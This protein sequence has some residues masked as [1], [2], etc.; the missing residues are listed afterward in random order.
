M[1]QPT[2][3]LIIWAEDN[4][5]LPVSGQPNKIIPQESLRKTGWDEGQ[6][7]SCE[8]FNYILN[9]LA[10]YIN[11]YGTEKTQEFLTKAANLSD[12]AD[13]VAARNNLSVYSQAQV[14]AK[15]INTGAGLTGGG[16]LSTNRTISMAT[17]STVGAGSTN[18]A[19]NG[20]NPTH[21]HTLDVTGNVSV[22]TG[23]V[24]N[25]GTIPLPSGY[26]ES[27]CKWTVSVNF[28][29]AGPGP[30]EIDVLTCSLN[31]RVVTITASSPDGTFGG[32][33]N[34]LIIGVK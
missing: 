19:T 1:A 31:G 33:A 21:T 10:Q 9:N 13:V 11:Y 15:Q 22:L 8:E 26:S 20:G 30:Y 28:A 24:S 17:P 2:D 6:K 12:L 23:T 7:P 34:Y 5:N 25:G 27:Q 14:D 4:V 29:S 32:T 18:S 3:P 16:D